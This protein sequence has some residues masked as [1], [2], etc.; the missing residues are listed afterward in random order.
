MIVKTGQ[1]SAY[2][3]LNAKIMQI[4]GCTKGAGKYFKTSP[5]TNQKI[6][7]RCFQTTGTSFCHP[8]DQEQCNTWAV[9]GKT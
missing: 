4:K 6:H 1:Q 9:K 3:Q 7:R 5:V 2:T 8:K